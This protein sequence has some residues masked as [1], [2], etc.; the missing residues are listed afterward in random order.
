[1]DKK[2]IYIVIVLFLLSLS[3][4]YLFVK[5][6]IEV[7]G[8]VIGIQLGYGSSGVGPLGNVNVTVYNDTF[9][10]WTLTNS[11]GNYYLTVENAGNYTINYTK[12]GFIRKSFNIT[13]PDIGRVV[14]LY[15]LGV[16]SFNV[17]VVDD[18][19]GR[20]I[21]NSNVIM[22]DDGCRQNIQTC[23]IGT[24]DENG[25]VLIGVWGNILYT[26]NVS[27]DG[28]IR[29]SSYTDIVSENSNKNVTIRLK[30][31]YS[32]YGKVND[33]YRCSGCQGEN[34]SNAF[35]ELRCGSQG[36]FKMNWTNQ[37]FYNTTSDS[38]GNY[39]INYPSTINCPV[40]VW[41][42]ATAE[43]YRNY[44]E[45]IG[46]PGT[47]Y[48]NILMTGSANLVG[49][50]FDKYAKNYGIPQA[51]I[52]VTSPTGVVYYSLYTENDGKFN[53]SVKD[54]ENRSI[55]VFK[56][57]YLGPIHVL[58]YSNT[59]YEYGRINL[60]GAGNFSGKVVDKYANV[61]L[62]NVSI[63]ISSSGPVYELITD[64]V[65]NFSVPSSTSFTYNLVFNKSGYK[66]NNSIT[67]RSPSYLGIINLEGNRKVN[68]SV[69]DCYNNLQLPNNK[70]NNVTVN[71]IRTEFTDPSVPS[72]YQVKTDSSGNYLIWI[73]SSIYGYNI[74]FSK[75]E[76]YLDKTITHLEPH[77][78][79]LNGLTNVYGHVVDKEALDNYK[80]ISSADVKISAGSKIFYTT[81]TD[82]NGNYVVRVG[83]L[84]NS[85]KYDVN[86]SK[87]GYYTAYYSNNTV[88]SWENLLTELNG[89]TSVNV[90]VLDAFNNQ[91]VNGSDVC[92][93]LEEIGYG[94]PGNETY[95]FYKKLTNT[96]GNVSF[97]IKG[98]NSSQKYIVDVKKTGYNPSLY[99]GPYNES[100][101]LIIYLTSQVTVYVYDNYAV[102]N[103]KPLGGAN[104][105]LYWNFT[106]TDFGPYELNETILNLTV[107]CNG[108]QRD[109][110][111]TTLIGLNYTYYDSKFTGDGL[112]NV[113]FRQVPI[114]WHLL[115][116]NGSDVGCDVDEGYLFIP[117]GG[118]IWEAEVD[119]NLTSAQ[120]KVINANTNQPINN[121]KIFLSTNPLINCTTNSS[122]LCIMYYVPGY[123][124]T[125][126]ITASGYEN[127]TKQYFIEP[128]VFNNFISDPV[129]MQAGPGNLSVY[130]FTNPPLDNINVT[131][132]NATNVFSS[133]TTNGWANFTNLLGSLNITANGSS[134][135]YN[136]SNVYNIWTDPVQVTIVNIKLIETY[137]LVT[138]TN[139]TGSP[140]QNVNVTVWNGSIGSSI[141]KNSSGDYLTGLTNSSGQIIFHR[142]VHGRYN[143][144]ANK[145]GYDLSYREFS[146][147]SGPVSET[148]VLGD[149]QPPQY[150]NV[151]QNVSTANAGEHVKVY[152]YWTDSFG[153]SLAKLSVNKTGSFENES[154]SISGTGNWS[155]FTI[156]TSGVT[157]PYVQWKIYCSDQNNNWNVTPL[158]SITITPLANLTVYV[159]DT[160]GANA[161]ADDLGNGPN[162]TISNS[163]FSQTKNTTNVG[164]VTFTNLAAGVYNI[165]VNG[166]RQGYGSNN[167]LQN[168]QL[169]VG[170]NSITVLLNITRLT[171]NVTNPNGGLIPNVNITV[172]NSTGNVH[173]N[174]TGGELIVINDDDG[175]VVF[176]RVLPCKN[177]NVSI[178]KL[179]GGYVFNSTLVNITEGNSSYVHLDPPIPGTSED[180][181]L[182]ITISPSLDNVSITATSFERPG[183]NVTNLTVSGQANLIVQTGYRYNLTIDGEPVGYG[184]LDCN[185]SY[186]P[187]PE[188]YCDIVV[189]KTILNNG[190]TA[191]NGRI[192]LSI[193]GSQPYHV[194]IDVYGYTPYDEENMTARV[195]N[196]WL[197]VG[198]NGSVLL[199]GY[200]YDKNFVNN[201]APVLKEPV[202]NATLFIFMSTTCSWDEDY[203][204]YKPI[205]QLNGSYTL[206]ISPKEYSGSIRNIS[207]PY[208]VKVEADGY[209]T[210]TTNWG[211]FEENSIE[212]RN[213]EM[214]GLGLVKGSVRD[215]IYLG[216]TNGS[217][218]LNNVTLTAESCYPSSPNCEAYFS[219]FDEYGNFSFYVS[220]RDKHVPYD[221]KIWPEDNS[222]YC[223]YTE[224][225]SIYPSHFAY[226]ELIGK[227]Y[228]KLKLNVT[229]PI[230]EN[231]TFNVSIRL[232]DNAENAT[233]NISQPRCRDSNESLN[234]LNCYLVSGNRRFI[235]N[236]SHLGYGINITE[237]YAEPPQTNCS[238]IVYE[239]NITLN[240]TRIN[241]T[242]IDDLGNT[243][244]NITVTMSSNPTFQNK[245]VNGS[246]VFEKVPAG[247]YNITFSGNLTEIY[248]YNNTNKAFLNVD[249]FFAGNMTTI[250]YTL[251]ETR[252]LITIRNESSVLPNIMLNLSGRQ[253]YSNITNESGQIWFRMVKPGN[254]TLVFNNSQLYGLGYIPPSQNISVVAGENENT[255]NSFNITLQSIDLVFDIRNTTSGNVSSNISVYYQG[256]L[257]KNGYGEDLIGTTNTTHGRKIFKN[258]IYRPQ[259]LYTY[260]VDANQSG[261]GI[262]NGS[263]NVTLNNSKNI[264]SLILPPLNITIFVNETGG[265]IKENV[266]VNVTYNNL[267]ATNAI[268]EYLAGNVS[269]TTGNITFR[270]LYVQPENYTVIVNSSRYFASSNN[271]TVL[272]TSVSPASLSFTLIE[273]LFNVYV[274]NLT[275][276]TLEEPVNVT[277]NTTDG[278]PV[279]GTNGQ[280]IGAKTG[281][282]NY[283]NFT[284]IPDGTYVINVKANLY[285]NSNYTF[286]TS[287][288][289]KGNNTYVFY[290]SKR[291]LT[292]VVKNTTGQNL[293]TPVT[294]RVVHPDGTPVTGTNGQII[295]PQNTVSN[296]TF[297]YLPDGTYNITINSTVYFNKTW[298]FN[299]SDLYLIN[300]TKT[301]VMSKRQV[302]IKAYD[303]RNFYHQTPFSENATF[304]IMNA[305]RILNN[306][307]GSPLIKTTDSGSTT[308]Y[309]I[310][311]GV[312][313]IVVNASGYYSESKKFDTNE[314]E[315]VEQNIYLYQAEYAYLNVSVKDGSNQPLSGVALVLKYGLNNIDSDYTN[316]NGLAVLKALTYNTLWQPDSV[317]NSSLGDIGGESTPTVFIKNDTWYLISGDS[318]GSFHGFNWSVSYWQSD[319]S[320]ISGLSGPPS[321]P[322]PTVFYKDGN[323]YLISGASNGLF[324]G[325]NW[326]GSSW[327][328]DPQI[329]SGLP[330]VGLSS[331]PTVFQKDGNWY[332][333]SGNKSGIF[334][335]FNWSGSSWQ[336]DPQIVSGLS[337]S[338]EKSKPFVFKKGNNLYLI[339]GAEDGKF[340]G[341]NWSGSS[342]QSDPQIVLGIEDVGNLSAPSIFQK[343][344]Y[345][346]LISGEEDGKFYGY[347]LT[348]NVTSLS[349]TASKTGYETVTV[350]NLNGTQKKISF[351]SIIMTPAPGQP[352]SGGGGGVSGG[353]VG[354]ACV[355]NWNCTEWSPCVNNVQT[356]TCIDL[357]KC[358]T[359]KNKPITSRACEEEII[360]MQIS[361]NPI[362][363]NANE[364]AETNI[365][366]ENKG[367]VDLRNVKAIQEISIPDCCIVTS[368]KAINILYA[369]STDTIP[370]RICSSKTSLKGDYQYEITVYS[371]RITE[372]AKS[373]VTILKSY[374]EILLDL[375]AITT[376][377]LN[378]LGELTP[379]QQKIRDEALDDLKKAREYAMGGDYANAERFLNEAKNKFEKIK[380]KPVEFNWMPIILVIIIGILITGLSGFIYKA[381]I[382]KPPAPPKPIS[383]KTTLADEINKLKSNLAKINE[384][385]L[386]ETEKYY[387]E[388]S[389][390]AL[391]RAEG[392]LNKNDTKAAS[393]YLTDL[394]TY[395]KILEYRLETNKIIKQF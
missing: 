21:P 102:D 321:A 24:T 58:P 7:S 215:I 359:V 36:Q 127:T 343:D 275:N 269:N 252:V 6:Q 354:I 46:T 9:L 161:E 4:F 389:L 242:L 350:E 289:E 151:G 282:T 277:L 190:T 5:A 280:I 332:L 160:T 19:N 234:I 239:F 66:L 361:I 366:I 26:F 232:S 387:Y 31:S 101:N 341:F 28:Y 201:Q 184:K 23:P 148:F 51:Q 298:Q 64:D 229:S 363:I 340:Y 390:E 143:L 44:F 323:L 1:M 74:T 314:Y 228:D 212:E 159:N 378:R 11:T 385:D 181:I 305:S 373:K 236:G 262:W 374:Q 40:F 205:T 300:S 100:K 261:Y 235:V 14:Y 329:V 285:F 328:S 167:S 17:T 202:D 348:Q 358:G 362:S 67:S 267:P 140:I 175:F 137:L 223:K 318:P 16:G 87:S 35:I 330:D 219:S 383:V 342:W 281:I 355:E 43:G 367:N 279:I 256:N 245:T 96:D 254:Y 139:T 69:S 283:T 8:T 346:Y 211:E 394:E 128:G 196:Q 253:T 177:C 271:F 274:R 347:N 30:G 370:I 315:G 336:S 241:I 118:I 272:N 209:K 324:F 144:S 195:G 226:Y 246:V 356:R 89:T 13:A 189:G 70:I 84:N 263:I 325:F 382:R 220:T 117:Y 334:L 50:V 388:K 124:R 123:N 182:N 268:S 141:A 322:T 115:K 313:D 22:M 368:E 379:E 27:S 291:S 381:K 162:V 99:N 146:I 171:V 352:P 179:Y 98:R 92:I 93:K 375:I 257:A 110:I 166:S 111:N 224:Y 32:V 218:T 208:C 216:P 113:T 164:Y 12:S 52:N 376:E 213:I 309:G 326:S 41:I 78:V 142:M 369:G 131:V 333:I 299:T 266:S 203:L 391:K 180:I 54:G 296:V 198:M 55:Y 192:D 225:D 306:L 349:I 145:T 217:E 238:P 308:L 345:W 365:F 73:A 278:D 384:A 301:F 10:N 221:I 392:Y 53:F 82:S 174:A 276:Q 393:R 29:N 85:A 178:E 303:I 265:V 109:G 34:I 138:V 134:E 377:D 372:K 294:I 129:L 311:D 230:N 292:V 173:K 395:I 290:L 247:L 132:R 108:S 60:T 88:G 135:G 357:N 249:D 155:N 170:S 264:V 176:N 191:T 231:L 187:Y 214:E 106:K 258:V 48:K 91:P 287:D 94:E 75:P 121:A 237:F 56:S 116:I 154:L 250:T 320:I 136:Y 80:N 122:G 72:S 90:T 259:E 307:T 147:S 327:Q 71:L 38:N 284:Y 360:R 194:R 156:D 206:Y 286:N 105:Y 168:V 104:V 331:A 39:V 81:S 353:V 270:Y 165:S 227:Y 316:S 197:L 57:G 63:S 130:V 25:N 310:P 302:L 172:Y 199:K 295:Q 3:L 312:F 83:F 149:T 2:S 288:I 126:N 233:L 251:N 380:K 59:S 185:E 386:T 200:V 244:D 255:N 193:P 207:Q 42:N 304:R 33:K 344:Y 114:G 45:S 120:F 337:I 97:N 153:L 77:D 119:I 248:F 86:I 335:G 68:G 20:P 186:H 240:L 103:K 112:K 76:E 293:E 49:E 79:C 152:A 169:N 163:T 158:S 133:L 62:A 371:D 125:F 37:Y 319:P 150:S 15:S 260:I 204:R 338:S 65:G 317:I 364:C 183:W 47:I 95:C 107:L 18:Q 297:N 210:N 61:G 188:G 243:L 157:Q 273:R 339:S 351:V 222:A